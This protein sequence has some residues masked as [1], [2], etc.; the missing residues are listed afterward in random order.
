[1]NRDITGSRVL[2][3]GG[4]RG[5]GRAVVDAFAA[6]KARVVTCHRGADRPT[7]LDGAVEVVTADLGDAAGAETLL[8]SA[9]TT[10]GGIDVLVNNVG[11]HGFAPFERLTEPEWNRVLDLN[12][13]SAYRVTRA[14]L[15]HLADGAAVVNIGAASA[16]RGVPGAVHHTAAKAA[17]I[18]FTRALCKELGPRG[19]R[20]NTIAP[21]M[22]DDGSGDDAGPVA[23]KVVAA[24][25]LGRLCTPAD[26]AGVVLFL[27]G[28]AA[29]FVSGTTLNVDGGI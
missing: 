17:L 24:T 26:V 28:P 15:P 23:A 20:V 22:V 18:G 27:T 3:T 19:I 10:L 4:T 29:G 13:T 12:V 2:V 9:G 16:L 8:A 6:A 25:P 1:M 11:A 14:A 5:I 7:D 21:G